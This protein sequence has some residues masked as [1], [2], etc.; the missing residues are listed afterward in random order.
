[1]SSTWNLGPEARE[2]ASEVLFTIPP[3]ATYDGRHRDLRSISWMG[4]ELVI[5]A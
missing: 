4:Q 1:M 3:Q 2:V 5:V